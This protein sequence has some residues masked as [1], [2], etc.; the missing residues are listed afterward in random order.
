MD[1]TES[2]KFDFEV[3][4]RSQE[5]LLKEEVEARAVAKTSALDTEIKL[6]EIALKEAEAKRLADEFEFKKQES[7]RSRWTNPIFVAI[8]GAIFVGTGNFA[9]SIVNGRAQRNLL[10]LSNQQSDSQENTRAENASILELIKTGDSEKVL[11][12]FCLLQ[13]LNSIHSPLTV[14]G[15]QI[16]ITDHHGCRKQTLGT[17]TTSPDSGRPTTSPDFG[18]PT[19]SGNSAEWISTGPKTIAGCG[20]SGCYAPTLVCGS[21]PANTK[22]TGNTRNFVDTFAGAWGEWTGTPSPSPT[23]VCRTFIQHSHNVQRVVSFEF[24]VVPIS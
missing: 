20:T 9:V 19:T 18:K 1:P 21:V 14:A 22:P 24:E 7:E 23:E 17:A 16:Y 11:T 4:S 2:E 15:V 3:K 13:S 5:I 6:R 8:I 12:G 10:D